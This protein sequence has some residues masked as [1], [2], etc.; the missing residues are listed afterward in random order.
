MQMCHRNPDTWPVRGAE[1]LE[2]G[3]RREKVRDR[4]CRRPG[5]CGGED[6]VILWPG[7]TTSPVS[8][9]CLPQ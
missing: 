4:T 2:A 9:K 7:Q 5:S 1:T 3:W 6:P 8:P